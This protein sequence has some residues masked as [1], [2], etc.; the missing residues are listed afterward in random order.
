M[1]YHKKN[2]NFLQKKRN[3]HKIFNI[4]S[5][6]PLTALKRKKK[7]DTNLKKWWKKGKKSDE[8]YCT[9]KKILKKK[10]I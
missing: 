4:F 3:S 2:K 6:Q 7:K 8:E 5:L 10:T 1:G 9:I